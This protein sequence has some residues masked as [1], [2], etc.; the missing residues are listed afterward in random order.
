MKIRKRVL[1]QLCDHTADQIVVTDG[2]Q[3]SDKDYP[4]TRKVYCAYKKNM[5]ENRF[6]RALAMNRMARLALRVGAGLAGVGWQA[7]ATWRSFRGGTCF[8]VV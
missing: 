1:D 8:V 5:H 4:K 3:V 6:R 2:N 7:F